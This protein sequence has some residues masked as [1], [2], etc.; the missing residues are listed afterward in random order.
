[1]VLL[2]SLFV[3][4]LLAEISIQF[5]GR[6]WFHSQIRAVSV[7]LQEFHKA[8]GDDARQK[9]LLRSGKVTLQFSF[10]VLLVISA[11]GAI[12]YIPVSLLVWDDTQQ[13][14]YLMAVSVS[15]TGWWLIRR[16]RNS[17]QNRTS[18]LDAGGNG[19]G[20]MDRWVHWIALAPSS[21]RHLAFDLERQYALSL[22]GASSSRDASKDPA[23]SA[24]YVC[25]LARSGTTMLLRI[26]DELGDFRSLTYR[27]MPFVLAPNLWK[28]VTRYSKQD[29]AVKERAH[30]DGILVSVDS[31]EGL[32][33][34]FWRTFGM[35]MPSPECFGYEEPTPEELQ[36]FAEY[37][38]LVANPRTEPAPSNGKLRRYL[39]KNNNNLLRLRSLSADPTATI[40]LVYRN[41]VATARSLHRQHQRFCASQSSDRFTRKY[42]GWLS[43]YEF[44]LDHLPFCFVMP[45]M[46]GKYTPDDL[47]YWLDYWN[48]VYRY[49]LSVGDLRYHLIN[50]DALRHSPEKVLLA[51]FSLLDVQADSRVLAQQIAAPDIVSSE[52]FCPELL[53]VV[54]ETYRMLLQSSKNLNV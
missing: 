11:L 33:E 43:H 31:P 4:I 40:L 52:G 19:Y 14:V 20:V 36:A 17:D 53:T 46:S 1:M 30:G 3:G 23:A 22:R 2:I 21:V 7:S 12:A 10:V 26:L 25:G 39:S 42:M 29:A 49:V 47:N 18:K 13:L 6:H 38:A 44:G 50:H 27:D 51:L 9:S 15:A 37:R 41:P 35:R 8:I 5:F 16:L 45:R 32:E 54:E 28:Q 48:A 24:V 34:V